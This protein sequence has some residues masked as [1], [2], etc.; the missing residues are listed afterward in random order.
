M[1]IVAGIALSEGAMAVD[2]SNLVWMVRN[3]EYSNDPGIIAPCPFVLKDK[4][5]HAIWISRCELMQEVTTSEYGGVYGGPS[6]RIASGLWW[7]V[8]GARGHKEVHS[9]IQPLDE[10][11][12]F[13]ITTHAVYFGG[14]RCNFRIPFSRV[15]KINP[16]SDSVGICKDGGREQIFL[17]MANGL[18]YYVFNLLE[19]IAHQNRQRDAANAPMQT[20]KLEI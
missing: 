6:V 13:A 5:E 11:G 7:R 18:A 14:K 10:M 20:F 8:G 4:N 1:G 12:D 17:T 3:N 15:L 2:F 16:Y 9:S 19:E